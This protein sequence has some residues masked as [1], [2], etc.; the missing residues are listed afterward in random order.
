MV[1]FLN[2]LVRFTLLL[3]LCHQRWGEFLFKASFIALTLFYTKWYLS[4]TISLYLTGVCMIFKGNEITLKFMKL[5]WKCASCVSWTKNIQFRTIKTTGK[6]LMEK[7]LR[8]N[9]YFRFTC[10]CCQCDFTCPVYVT[11]SEKKVIWS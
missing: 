4:Q 8:L 5:L 10:V 6:K 2:T 11:D 7:P 3:I 1:I 9:I